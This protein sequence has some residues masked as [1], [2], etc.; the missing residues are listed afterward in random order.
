MRELIKIAAL[1]GVASVALATVTA[2]ARITRIEIAKTEPAFAGQSFGA[3]D[4]IRSAP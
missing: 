3:I 2:E 4:G 1:S